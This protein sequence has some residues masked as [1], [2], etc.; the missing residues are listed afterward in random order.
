MQ[1]FVVWC[2]PSQAPGRGRQT[3]QFSARHLNHLAVVTDP[4]FK[5]SLSAVQP[6]FAT[7]AAAAGLEAVRHSMRIRT[8]IMMV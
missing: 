7:A 3:L 2:N 1:D 5:H 8:V 6:P 4:L